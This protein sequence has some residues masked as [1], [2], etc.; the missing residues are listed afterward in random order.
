MNLAQ[1]EHYFS[2]FLQ[3]LERPHG[4][5]R[6]AASRPEL[7]AP[8]TRSPLADAELPRTLRFVGTVNFDETT[9]QLSQRVLDRANLIRL[10]PRY[11]LDAGN[12]RGPA[13]PPGRRSRCANSAV[14]SRESAGAGP[15][16]WA[17]CSTSSRSRWPS[18]AVRSTLAASTPSAGCSATLRPTSARR[19]RPSTCRSPSASCR[20]SATCS[21][22]GPA[23]LDAIAKTLEAQPSGFAES[24]LIAGRNPGQ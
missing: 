4:R 1:V 2:G 22:R 18:W 14:G 8:P 3:A 19:S 21:G 9:R 13:S 17:S 10:P 6:S 5:A 11:L 12:R 24:L 15:L 16:R 7:V 23:R 20:R